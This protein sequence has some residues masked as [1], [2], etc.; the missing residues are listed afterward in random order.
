MICPHCGKDTSASQSRCTSCGRSVSVVGTSVLTPPPLDPDMTMAGETKAPD[1][2]K[3][4]V[5][6]DVTRAPGPG[7]SYLSAG[8]LAIGQSFGPRYRI[9]KMLGIGGMGAVYQ[10]WDNELEVVV[11]IKV[12]RPEATADPELLAEIE[13]RFKQ[14]LLLA[15]QV[16]HTNVVRIHDLG[17]IKGIKYIT[18]SY[19]EGADL[20]T[21]LQRDGKLK[22]PVALALTRQ[23]ASGLLAAHEAGVVHRDLKP[24]NIMIEGEQ[25]F[26][27][28]FGIARSSGGAQ[29]P[30]TPKNLPSRNSPTM[31]QTMQGAIVGTITYMAP[32]QAA[33]EA[34]DQR[35]DMYALGMIV[36]DM[37]LGVHRRGEGFDATDDLQRRMTERPASL[38][39]KDQTIP[40][41]FDQIITRLLEPD[42]KARFQT[43]AELVAA[44]D[45]LDDKGVPLPLIRRL[46]PRMIASAAV[47]VLVLVAATFYFT[48]QSI[49][50]LNV[51][52]D[53]VSVLIADFQNTTN[54]AAFNTILGS[55][56]Q[57]A[58]EGA[59][60][61][62]AYDRIGLNTTAG[63]VVPG[64][65]DETAARE[66]AAKQGFG[67]IVAGSIATAGSGYN[68]SI[69]AMQ[70]ATGAV[71]ATSDRNAATKNDV[72][73][74]M[75]RLA[76]AVRTGL[77]DE[78]KEA[79]HVRAMASLSATSLD[80]L[81]QYVGG[82]DAAANGRQEEAREKFSAAL[83][84][85]SKFGPAYTSLAA[86]LRSL[87]RPQDA[88]QYLKES[89]NNVDGMTD[90][91][92]LRARGYFY[93]ATG[94][95]QKCADEYGALI[96]QFEADVTG[97]E[98]RALCLTRLRDI[99]GALAEIRYVVNLLPGRTLFRNNLAL[100]ADYAGQFPI[101]EEEARALPAN[102]EQA[103]L[104]LA[105]AQIGQDKLPDA[106]ATYDKLRSVSPLGG[107]LAATGVAD[108]AIVQGRFGDAARSLEKDA[109]A[110]L[111]AKNNDLAASKY[112]AMAYAE[113]SRGRNPIAVAAAEKALVYSTSVKVRFLAARTLIEA[114]AEAKARPVIDGLAAESSVEAQAHAKIL[115]GDVA[116]K[117][118]NAREAIKQLGAANSQLD[119]WIGRFD[120]G[121]AQLEAGGYVQADSEIDRCLKRRGEAL[122]LF[123][124][125]DPTFGYFPSVYYYQGR[126]REAMKNPGA[127]AESYKQYLALR[128]QSKEDPLVTDVR[129]R[130]GS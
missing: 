42:P 44:L 66:I 119:T 128:G 32:E 16:T 90:R 93:L 85:N 48:R 46:T 58:L 34:V 6:S 102:F 122:S 56:F 57:R 72:V 74:A 107:S 100:Y 113:L 59:G 82:M 115:E 130:A 40:E 106:I 94:D 77:G 124:D 13:R 108:I 10:A 109:A 29:A 41:A 52:H 51:Q 49:P 62:T 80:V 70:A 67:V 116:L 30:L 31:A 91:E 127:A 123:L 117:S 95:Y 97:R 45:R 25:A 11:A 26:I 55:T 73:A 36:S 87:G 22:V 3:T 103:S 86:V 101:A 126:I 76:A 121:R 68:L 78:T 38:R 54:D 69:K 8:P 2:F 39:E 63:V 84:L 125:E 35:A 28:D 81:Q 65:L 9:V 15:R 23:I 118:G 19:I 43:T 89:L 12:I 71:I 99:E 14:E 104:A 79:D 92:K 114:G 18:M 20:A 110:E 37:L 50:L 88:E 112:V 129:K 47:L 7:D 1:F 120:L 60:F 61:V 96:K 64:K 111:A 33:G 27:M 83:G 17:E 53:P 105:M 5:L 21:V 75:T 4:P 24:A 98:Q